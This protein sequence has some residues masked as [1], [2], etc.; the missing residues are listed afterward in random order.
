[1]RQSALSESDVSL[2][3]TD[4]L[5]DSVIEKNDFDWSKQ[6]LNEPHHSSTVDTYFFFNHTMRRRHE[7][8]IQKQL[9]DFCC[10]AFR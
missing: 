3:L 7:A 10:E 4:G 5:R 6:M 9:Q 8:Q 1:M 2:G